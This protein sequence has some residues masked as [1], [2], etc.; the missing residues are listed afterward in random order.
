MRRILIFST[1][2]F[3][4]VGGA[5][6][7]VKELTDRLQRGYQ[8]DLICARLRS[9]IPKM[10]KVGNVTVH[11]VGIGIPLLDKLWLPFGGTIRALQLHKEKPYDVFWS[12]MVTYA[13]YAAY[14]ANWFLKKNVPIVVT[15]QEGDSDAYLRTK[16][17]GIIHTSWKSML[18]RARLVTVISSY[19]A[20]RAK[21]LGAKRIVLVPNGVDLKRFSDIDARAARKK[22][23]LAQSDQVIVTTSRLVEKN[24]V[25][26]VIRAIVTIPH[27]LFIIAGDGPLRGSLEALAKTCGVEDRVRF[28]GSVPYDEV[29]NIVAAGDVFVRASRSE[30][31]GN[32]FIEAMAVGTPVVGTNIGGI[33]DFLTDAIRHPTDGT[34]LMVPPEDVPALAHALNRLLTDTSL[35]TA[36]SNRA[37]IF[38]RERYGWDKIAAQMDGAFQQALG[39]VDSPRVLVATGLFPP[40]G[41]GPATYSKALADFLPGR[42]FEVDIA[43]FRTVRKFPKIIRHTVYFFKV[44]RRGMRADI[45]FAQDPVSVGVPAMVAALI[46][47]KKFV[48]KVVGDYAWEQSTQR[49]HYSGTIDAFQ[50][51]SLGLLAGILRAIERAV[52]RRAVRVLVPSK[53][54]GRIVSS[55]GVPKKNISV[56]YNG[57][58]PHQVGLKQVIR[59]LLRFRGELVMSSGR[60]VPWKGHNT[61]IRIHAKMAKERPDLHLLIVAGGP[62]AERLEK[63]AEDLGVADSVIFT[64][65]VENAV[66]L[67]YMRAA[68]VFALNTAY[69][70]FSHTLLEAAAV[71]V[72][73]VTTAIGG[74]PEFIDDGVN[75]Y[76]VKP[77]DEKAFIKKITA[78]LDSPELR[79]KIAGNA[80]RKVEKFSVGAM[81]D[82]TAEVLKNICAS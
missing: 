66:A 3:P 52:A 43:P 63:L 44:L 71:G 28:L 8:C 7:A 80:K 58:A 32:S 64:G 37:R 73:I 59:G 57:I 1:A 69:E 27:A 31:F 46:L 40:E 60:L 67:R 20:T 53:Y 10:E 24:G 14:S 49:F 18:K 36:L 41:G 77:D 70:G 47:R 16:W 75:G 62:E 25:D 26:L 74:N 78:L 55:W 19:L 68:D 39:A 33:P 13:T 15:L 51:D 65:N 72:P 22:M 38:V 56:V 11:R 35:R 50:N 21:A 42:G 12:M 61:L 6:V 9:D 4:F 2:Y 29:H 45:I 81:V 82:R 30:G 48:L 54:L 5:E 23:G 79:A 76:L 17:F 34:G